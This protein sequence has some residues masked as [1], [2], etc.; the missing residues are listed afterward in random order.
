MTLKL[1]P[2][3]VEE[4]TFK[5]QCLPALAVVSFTRFSWVVLNNFNTRN[6]EMK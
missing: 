1:E 2:D 4:K 3:D 6:G 5:V